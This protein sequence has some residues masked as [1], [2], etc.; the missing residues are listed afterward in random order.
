[1]WACI[2]KVAF[3]YLIYYGNTQIGMDTL[4]GG[5]LLNDAHGFC[6][7]ADG[8]L[9]YMAANG[10]NPFLTSLSDKATTLKQAFAEQPDEKNDG[11]EDDENDEPF[12][13]DASENFPL[14]QPDQEPIVHI[15]TSSRSIYISRAL[16]HGKQATVA[17][18]RAPNHL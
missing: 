18:S 14:I 13:I 5:Y 11:E 7:K 12:A 8:D 2:A 3:T 4:V 17:I 6:I 9:Q 1:M 10:K 15:Q 16:L